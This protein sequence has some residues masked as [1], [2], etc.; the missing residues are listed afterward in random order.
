MIKFLICSIST[1]FLSSINSRPYL[2]KATPNLFFHQHFA[3]NAN[4]IFNVEFH[5][6]L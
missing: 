3:A 5:F 6:A 1:D 2:C 4:H